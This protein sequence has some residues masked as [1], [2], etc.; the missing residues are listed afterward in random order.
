MPGQLDARVCCDTAIYTGASLTFSLTSVG[1]QLVQWAIPQPYTCDPR[2]GLCGSHALPFA[3]EK[4]ELSSP[5]SNENVNMR[6]D[7]DETYRSQLTGK[8]G[9]IG[10]QNGASRRNAGGSPP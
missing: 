3:D 9:M 1:S 6:I 4:F 10:D 8:I 7:K 2:R 5:D